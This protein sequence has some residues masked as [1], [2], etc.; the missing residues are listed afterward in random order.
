M[1]EAQVTELLKSGDRQWTAVMAYSDSFAVGVSRALFKAGLCVPDDVS[2]VGFDNSVAE[3]FCPP[4][5]TIDH[6]LFQMGQAAGTLAMR[7]FEAPAAEREAIRSEVITVDGKF[8][9][10]QSTAAAKQPTG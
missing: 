2:L 4:L 5:T 8:T 7:L 3:S 10:R 9:Q 1:V 6:R